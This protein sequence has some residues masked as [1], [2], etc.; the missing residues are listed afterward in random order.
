MNPAPEKNIFDYI[1]YIVT[2]D[3]FSN[4]FKFMVN[5]G[6]TTLIFHFSSRKFTMVLP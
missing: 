1:P 5:R 2:G 3:L 6:N 4:L